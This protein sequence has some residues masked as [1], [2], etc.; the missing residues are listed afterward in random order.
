MPSPRLSNRRLEKLLSVF[1][2]DG[3]AASTVVTSAH[4]SQALPAEVMLLSEPASEDG[5]CLQGFAYAIGLET[6]TALCVY[7]AWQ[8]WQILR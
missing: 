5:L 7:G 8:A 4:H 1:E 6:A 2:T 3:F